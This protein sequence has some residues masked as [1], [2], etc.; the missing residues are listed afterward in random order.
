VLS[1]PLCAWD[2]VSSAAIGFSTAANT[3]RSMKLRKLSAVSSA[4]IARR[5]RIMA[6]ILS[7]SPAWS[8]P[9]SRSVLTGPP[10]AMSSGAR[11][12]DVGDLHSPT[13]ESGNADH[14]HGHALVAGDSGAD[15]GPRSRRPHRAAGV[16]VRR[17]PST[18]WSRSSRTARVRRAPTARRSAATARSTSS[19]PA[20]AP[21]PPPGRTLEGPWRLTEFVTP[22]PAWFISRR[23]HQRRQGHV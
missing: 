21:P 15:R 22:T 8:A 10:P 1:M 2:S 20:T 6:T 4:R 5:S 14:R 11:A 9:P 17:R 23:H 19:T 18:S 16:R 12:G 13:E 7:F 3:A